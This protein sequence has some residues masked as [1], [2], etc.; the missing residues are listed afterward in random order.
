MKLSTTCDDC[1][2]TIVLGEM[3]V[4]VTLNPEWIVVVHAHRSKGCLARMKARVPD[5]PV[6]IDGTSNTIR[7]TNEG[8]VVA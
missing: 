2:E 3:W 8:L 1:G 4:K 5:S 6:V 7:I